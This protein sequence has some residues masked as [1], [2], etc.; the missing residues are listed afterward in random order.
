MDARSA[1]QWVLRA[2]PSNELAHLTNTSRPP[3]SAARFPAPIGAK[4]R[5]M[6]TQDRV[7]LDNAG[8]TKQAWPKPSYPYQQ[9]PVAPMELPLGCTPQ[10]NIELMP[11]KEILKLNSEP[12]L[13]QVGDNCPKQMEHRNHRVDGELILPHRANRADGIFGNDNPYIAACPSRESYPLVAM[14]QSGQD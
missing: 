11:K 14:M 5:S 2:H 12:R 10:G 6:P 3:W 8:Q 9:C 4:P 1:P 7:R 13:E